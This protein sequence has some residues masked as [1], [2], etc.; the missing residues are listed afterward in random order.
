M[1]G[2]IIFTTN[3]KPY[4]NPKPEATDAGDGNHPGFKVRQQ[5][6]DIAAL[7]SKSEGYSSF[8]LFTEDDMELCSHGLLAAQYMLNKAE[9]YSPDFMTIRASYGMNGIFM[10]NRDMAAFRDYLIEHQERRPPDHLVVEWFGGEKPQSA[11]LKAGRG[12]LAFRFNILHHLGVVSTL[13]S[14]KSKSFPK[15]FEELGEPTLFKVEAF[16]F[17]AC[18]D[19]D[20]WP[21]DVDAR[22]K[23]PKIAWGEM[24]TGEIC[25]NPNNKWKD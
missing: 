20:V 6:R 3:D 1:S 23:T 17:R 4:P 13:R 24:C 15:C 22:A 19:D 11:A 25:K 16:D 14:A 2:Y 8:Y 10:R 21:C 5:T 12:H 9:H 7:M 18:R